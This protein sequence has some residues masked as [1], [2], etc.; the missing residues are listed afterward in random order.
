MAQLAAE[1][2]RRFAR[3]VDVVKDPITE[4]H[5]PVKLIHTFRS[6]EDLAPWELVLDRTYGGASDALSGAGTVAHCTETLAAPE[7]L[8]RASSVTR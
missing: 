2:R 3:L 8:P 7:E 1:L 5:E 4:V 6:E